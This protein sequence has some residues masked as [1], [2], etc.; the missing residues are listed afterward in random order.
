MTDNRA[1]YLRFHALLRPDQKRDLE[2][3]ESLEKSY[4]IQVYIR[5]SI[6]LFL[7]THPLWSTIQKEAQRNEVMQ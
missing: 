3:L 6:D 1:K 5:R 4:G 2:I 7:T